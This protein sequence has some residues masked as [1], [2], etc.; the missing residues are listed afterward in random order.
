MI[1]TRS[2]QDASAMPR[3]PGQVPS[4]RRGLCQGCGGFLCYLL[5]F[6]MVVS[7][8]T[9]SEMLVVCPSDRVSVVMVKWFKSASVMVK[10][11]SAMSSMVPV[12]ASQDPADL[13]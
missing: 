5:V 12:G 1:N 11:A 2:Y 13:C 6:S 10:S 7:L 8:G 9:V 3:V 4:A